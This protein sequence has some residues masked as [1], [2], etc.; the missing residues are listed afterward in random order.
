VQGGSLPHVARRLRIP[1]R[2]VDH[3]LSEVREFIVREE[4]L[5]H[6]RRLGQ[7]PLG[8][9][10]WVGVLIRDGR[11]RTIADDVVLEPGDHVH[12]YCQPED[13]AALERIFSGSR[14]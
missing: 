10:A 11:P 1:F 6:G 5:A 13:A 3:D 2:S 7:L 9:R 14:D 8:E 12:V 4:A